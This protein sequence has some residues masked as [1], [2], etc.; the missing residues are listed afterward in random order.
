MDGQPG[1]RGSKKSVAAATRVTVVGLAGS[2][3][4]RIL[5]CVSTAYPNRVGW[6]RIFN[7]RREFSGCKRRSA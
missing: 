2:I 3:A 1:H 7:T 5:W 4:Y 6:D